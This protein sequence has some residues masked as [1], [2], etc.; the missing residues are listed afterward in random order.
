VK[1]GRRKGRLRLRLEPVEVAL[2]QSLFDQLEAVLDGS[3]DGAEPIRRRLVPDGYRDDAAAAAE[4]RQLTADTL[5]SERDERIA[6]CRAELA[7][8]GEV[9]LTDPDT[10]RRWIQVLNDLRLA[11]GTRLGVTEDDGPHL[12]PDDPDA[13]LR[14][15]YHWLSAVQDS[16]V[17]ELIG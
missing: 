5:R 2:L 6:A 8:S 16:V 3:D 12:D 14:A 4:F 7:A 9:D 10:A 13:E 15:I 11:F 17:S 1:V